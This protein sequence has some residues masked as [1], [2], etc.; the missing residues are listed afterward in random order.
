MNIDQR[1][2][3]DGPSVIGSNNDSP[4]YGIHNRTVGSSTS[5]RSEVSCCEKNNPP[6]SMVV[7][8]DE[9]S[10]SS[11]GLENAYDGIQTVKTTSSYN[12]GDDEAVEKQDDTLTLRFIEK[13][14]RDITGERTMNCCKEPTEKQLAAP[15]SEIRNDTRSSLEKAVSPVCRKIKVWATMVAISGEMNLTN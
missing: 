15:A 14:N 5:T 2:L 1:G 4:T 11:D 6:S 10:K 8:I 9:G 13:S 12:V 3:Q 7:D